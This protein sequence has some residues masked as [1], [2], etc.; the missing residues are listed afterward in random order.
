MTTATLTYCP[1]AVVEKGAHEFLE[2]LFLYKGKPTDLLPP[3]V[4]EPIADR[5]LF[6]AVLAE[7]DSKADRPRSEVEFLHLPPISAHL[8]DKYRRTT[9]LAR[10]KPP[11]FGIGA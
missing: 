7:L 4:S 6:V 5:E 3:V 2:V 11:M 10:L 9:V 8:G 1:A